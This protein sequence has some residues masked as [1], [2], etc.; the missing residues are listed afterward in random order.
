MNKPQLFYK[1]SH[2]VLYYNIQLYI[3]DWIVRSP[4]VGVGNSGHCVINT[5]VKHSV[6]CHVYTLLVRANDDCVMRI[7][8]KLCWPL[9][10][11]KDESLHLTFLFVF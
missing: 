11:W 2:P 1:Q 8:L 3:L 10:N 7:A 6:S 5:V 4:T 9:E